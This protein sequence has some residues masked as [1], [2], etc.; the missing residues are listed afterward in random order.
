MRS[1]LIHVARTAPFMVIVP[2]VLATSVAGCGAPVDGLG[3]SNDELSLRGTV[4]DPP[5]ATAPVAVD[6]GPAP[7]VG[8]PLTTDPNWVVMVTMNRSDGSATSCSAWVINEHLRRKIDERRGRRRR[9]R[10]PYRQRRAL[11]FEPRRVL[12]SPGRGQRDDA[13]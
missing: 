13:S 12:H 4:S 6:P 9:S 1:H 10:G 5:V 7:I 2:A 3:K 8:G 11:A